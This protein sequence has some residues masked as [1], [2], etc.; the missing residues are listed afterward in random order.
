MSPLLP[1]SFII[2]KRLGKPG[3]V[4]KLIVSMNLSLD[5]FV[6][7]AHDELDWHF[8][9][10]SEGMGEKLLEVLDTTDTLLL[11]RITYEAMACYWPYKPLEQNFPRQDQ[12]IA[13][14]MNRHEKIVFSRNR[15][16]LFWKNSKMATLNCSEEIS[17]LRQRPGKNLLIF[18]SAT[19]VSY[20]I[21]AGL[22]DEYLLWIHPVIL[23]KGNPL[24]RN[25][26]KKTKLK[27]SGSE[28][29]EK[30]VTLLRYN[31]VN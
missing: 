18:G 15:P 13:D 12:A 10:W 9:C 1:T 3:K 29:F 26:E 14:Q 27:L 25:H 28:I 31:P 30:G 23:G 8:E 22:V 19:L 16:A 6:S 2:K 7:G 4:R 24:F 5:G 21:S 11:G 17:L 20:C